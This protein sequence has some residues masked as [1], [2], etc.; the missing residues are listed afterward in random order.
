MNPAAVAAAAFAW[1]LAHSARPDL[2]VDAL[3][4]AHRG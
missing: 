4:E 3:R 1:S 2:V